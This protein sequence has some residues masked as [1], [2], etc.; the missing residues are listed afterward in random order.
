MIKFYQN[1]ATI[2]LRMLI[3]IV[4][5]W[6]G[7]GYFPIL[8]IEGDSALFSAGCERL[9]ANGF[10]LPP[11]YFY[12]WDMQPLVGSLIVGVKYL[13]PFFSCEQIYNVLTIFCSLSYLFV[14]SFFVSKLT[15]LRWEYSFL[16]LILFPESYSIGYYSNTTIFASLV[17][18]LGFLIILK[19]PINAV[20]VILLGVA[21]LL[22]VDV[23]AIYPLVFFLF[24]WQVDFKKSILY[25]G[26][27]SISV[28]V[29]SISGFCLLD[30]NPLN[31]F[32]HYQSL[33][34]NNVPAFNF[35]S[36]FK[37]NA[38]YYSIGIILLIVIGVTGL[39][40]SKNYKLLSLSLL[41]VI[42]LYY[43]FG[44]FTGAATKHIHYLLPFVGLLVAFSIIE[45]RKQLVLRKYAL[46]ITICTIIFLQSFIGV[47]FYPNSKP[48]I[49]KSYAVLNSRPKVVNLR[50]TEVKQYGKLQLVF[51]AG[52][53]IPTADELMLFSGNFF[54]PFYWHSIKTDELR[55][56]KIIEKLILESNDTLYFMTTQ[57]SD[58]MLSQQL[59]SLGFHIVNVKPDKTNTAFESEFWFELK[60]KKIRVTR[61]NVER[62]PESFNNAFL[63]MSKKPLYLL[64][65]WDW[66][67]YLINEKFTRAE[68]IS[69]SLSIVR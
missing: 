10:K 46:T 24:W 68:P 39:L 21:P 61:I 56:R 1:N 33:V 7:F 62:T 55:E 64:T 53:I 41:P 50:S 18:L 27:Y 13:F 3:L 35:E 54:T 20:S 15:T 11:D 57:S 44:D 34:D 48:W 25:S 6:L 28:L 17:S 42:T 2:I 22:R 4:L 69:K 49:S 14:A 19:K 67:L 16:I 47:Q 63:K 31:T 59:H 60:N 32:N 5:L 30:A 8:N 52:Q 26:F 9:Y 58:W 51:G 43:L 66:Q 65:R 40:K 36:F 29:I 38:S 23:L 12:Q 37:I 45:L